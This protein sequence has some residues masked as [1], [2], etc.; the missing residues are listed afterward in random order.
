MSSALGVRA[1]LLSAGLTEFPSAGGF[2]RAGGAFPPPRRGPL[3]A[4]GGQVSESA[5]GTPGDG[6]LGLLP[7]PGSSRGVPSFIAHGL[8]DCGVRLEDWGS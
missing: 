6:C 3:G 5:S 1:A 8:G 7:E 2:T 4:V